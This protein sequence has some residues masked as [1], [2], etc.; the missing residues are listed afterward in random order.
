MAW[1][2]T[3]WEAE[4]LSRVDLTRSFLFIEPRSHFSSPLCLQD[5]YLDTESPLS[6]ESQPYLILKPSTQELT[7]GMEQFE[8][9]CQASL[10]RC[11]IIPNFE[12]RGEDLRGVHTFTW[13]ASL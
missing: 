4:A 13:S 10:K 2:K 5:G 7:K 1:D 3:K 8:Y 12:S 11:H 6:V 9:C